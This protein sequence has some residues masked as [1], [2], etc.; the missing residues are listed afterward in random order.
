MVTAF[1]DCLN[2][3]YFKQVMEC[4]G[5]SNCA[6]L[7]YGD[8]QQTVGLTYAELLDLAAEADA[9]INISGHLAYEPLRRRL[10]RKVYLDIDPGFTQFWHATG[11]IDRHLRGHDFYYTIGENIGTPVCSIPTGDIVWRHVRQPVV[12]DEWPVCPPFPLPIR[13]GA[14][15][16]APVRF[17]TIASWRGPYGPVEYGGKAFGLKVHEFRKFI[18]LPERAGQTFEIALAIHPADEQDR[19]ALGRHGWQLVDPKSVAAGS[20]CVSALRAGLGR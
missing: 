17:T 11:S 1:E 18:E 20:G 6:S 2:L 10:R 8:E 9:L 16:A 4:F 5:L 13:E 3:A 19:I 14:E 15:E 7:L 12:L